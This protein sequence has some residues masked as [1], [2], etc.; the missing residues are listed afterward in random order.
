MSDVPVQGSESSETSV[1]PPLAQQMWNLAR[2]L[3][4]FVADGCKTVDEE[5][6]RQRLEICDACRYRR[7]NR[8]MKCGCFLSM[9]A[10]GRAFKCPVR[11]WPVLGSP[12]APC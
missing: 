2:S 8:C 10:R 3:A 6:Y 12:D 4:D 1:P 9:K 7:D 11:L 5:Q